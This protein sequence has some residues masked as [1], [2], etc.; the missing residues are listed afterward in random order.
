MILLATCAIWQLI[1]VIVT[2]CRRTSLF[3]YFQY[4]FLQ[5][6]CWPQL[7]LVCWP[8]MAP[9]FLLF[10]C[11]LFVDTQ[12]KNF[13]ETGIRRTK[14]RGLRGFR[15][16]HSVPSHA[17]HFRISTYPRSLN[18]MSK[19]I[20]TV[21]PDKRS[22]KTCKLCTISREKLSQ[23]VFLDPTKRQKCLSENDLQ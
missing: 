11:W 20:D 13:T 15:L 5:R 17:C 23:K 12:N 2:K 4:L 8:R 9:L 7:A 1:L 19:N 10:Y 18:I 16:W 14:F 22:N 21:E 3:F 6:G